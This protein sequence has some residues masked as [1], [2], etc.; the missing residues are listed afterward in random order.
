MTASGDVAR[1]EISAA[2]RRMST[3]RNFAAKGDAEADQVNRHWPDHTPSNSGAPHCFGR[4][5]RSPSFL[6]G[7]FQNR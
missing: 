5:N 4:S 1:G 2:R 7:R 6:L 3:W